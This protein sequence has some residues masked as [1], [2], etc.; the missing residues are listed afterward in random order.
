MDTRL[1]RQIG[2]LVHRVI[3]RWMDR[4]VG[5][6][7]N[8]REERD[9]ARPGIIVAVQSFGSGFKSNVHF[10]ILMTDGVYFPDGSYFA[11]GFW[12]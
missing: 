1:Q 2:R 6:H 7:R 9:Q 3:T 11:L 8:R 4:Q 5:C 10:H 12:D